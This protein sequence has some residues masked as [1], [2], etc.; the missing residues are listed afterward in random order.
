ML[1]LTVLLTGKALLF[2]MQER[3]GSIPSTTPYP[4][5]DNLIFLITQGKQE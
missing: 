2:S 5:K 1:G 4:K 3:L